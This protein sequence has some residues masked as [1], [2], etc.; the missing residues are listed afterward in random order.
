MARPQGVFRAIRE[1]DLEVLEHA[2]RDDD[3]RSRLLKSRFEGQGVLHWACES[4]W[5]EGAERLLAAGADL[6]AKDDQGNTPLALAVDAHA[7]ELVDFLLHRGAEPNCENQWGQTPLQA[8]AEFGA[9]D[10]VRT[11]LRAG[12]LP[13]YA[14]QPAA[15]GAHDEVVRVLVEA[16]ADVN[17]ESEEVEAPLLAAARYGYGRESTLELL[18][19]LGA[20]PDVTTDLGE[21]PLH[22]A[23]AAHAKVQILDRLVGL[24]GVDPLDDQGCSPLHAAA[25]AVYRAGVELLLALGADAKRECHRGNSPLH[26]FFE[27]LDAFD[28]DDA[29]ALLESLVRAGADPGKAN[30]RG[31][32]PRELGAYLPEPLLKVLA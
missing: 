11:L 25:E 10:I 29:A 14:L 28:V 31:K 9:F 23:V 1:H 15:M 7:I 8:A 24:Y 22:L 19:S 12:A 4:A 13:I 20:S 30:K 21:T 27:D 6:E 26:A 17:E 2:L 32:T 16:G 3:S 5:A 18:L